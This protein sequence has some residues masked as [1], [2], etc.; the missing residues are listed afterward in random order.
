M[1]PKC[2]GKIVEKASKG[3]EGTGENDNGGENAKI[4]NSIGKEGMK[5]VRAMEGNKKS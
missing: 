2:Q 5:L 1:A 4:S 3:Q